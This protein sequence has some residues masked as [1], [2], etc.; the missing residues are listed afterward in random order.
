SNQPSVRCQLAV[1]RRQLPEE[2]GGERKKK[3]EGEVEDGKWKIESGEQN[4]VEDG[5][6]LL[7]SWGRA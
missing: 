4:K 7:L 6:T 2:A 5:S 1:A 3:E